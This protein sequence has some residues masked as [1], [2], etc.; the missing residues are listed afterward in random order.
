MIAIIGAMKEEVDAVKKHMV[1]K[2]ED[3]FL[4]LPYY[5][6]EIENKEVILLQGGIGKV[7]TAVYLTMLLNQYPQVD[8]IINVGSAGG[9][10][11]NQ[12]VGDVVIA[13]EVIHH[14]M[15]VENFGYSR[16]QVPGFSVKSF[17]CD[18]K[19]VELAKNI[20]STKGN[21][22]MG[23]IVSGD[24]FI[25]KEEQVNTIKEYFDDAMCCEMEAAS[26]GHVCH[27]FKKKFIITR[28]ISDVYGN[29]DSGV[30]FDEYL[31]KASHESALM[32]KE[33]VCK[34]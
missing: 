29:G 10:K 17:S 21:V 27:L 25:C 16:G 11:C 32:C 1:I 5:I 26:I 20:I 34:I 24:Q 19:L 33:L 22:H 3:H 8:I 6:G 31:E 2:K 15:D 18:Q 12:K 13:T 7:N 30:Q 28:S 9:L 4:T 23:V 14:D